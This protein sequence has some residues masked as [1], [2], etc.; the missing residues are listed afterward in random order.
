M[1]V[2]SVAR[3]PPVN[4]ASMAASVAAAG[5][6][7]PALLVPFS[8]LLAASVVPRARSPY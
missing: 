2:P 7:C 4:N 1:I 3:A 6:G 8:S 5:S